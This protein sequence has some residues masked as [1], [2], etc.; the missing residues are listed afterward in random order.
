[1]NGIDRFVTDPKHEASIE[2]WIDCPLAGGRRPVDQ[3]AFNLFVDNDGDPHH[4]RMD[5]R[6]WFTDAQGRPL[7][8]LGSKD[9]KDDP[10]F[11]VWTDTTTLYTKIVEGHKTRDDA[12]GAK[13]VASGIVKI[14]L[15]DF[16]K[17][18]TTFHVDG[19]TVADRS[20]AFARFGRLFLGSLWDVY[21][22]HILSYGPL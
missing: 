15:T 3:G 6:L 19:P 22:S 12:A 7:T 9:V 18:L 8:L 2:G 5:Y 16:L 20:A 11:D 14:Q 17:E 21:A 1:M 4:K 10:G 13:V